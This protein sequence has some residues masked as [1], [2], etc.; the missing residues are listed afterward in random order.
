[1]VMIILKSLVLPVLAG[2]GTI[3]LCWLLPPLRKWK[4]LSASAF[5]LAISFSAFGAWLAEKGVPNFPPTEMAEWLGVMALLAG[6]AAILVPC[7]GAKKF[8]SPEIAAC[9]MG[10]IVAAGPMIAQM[11]GATRGHY[12]AD[13]TVPDH[14][15]M[16]MAMALGF[17]IFDR[18]A[19]RQPG[20]ILPLV[21]TIVFGALA[22]LADAAG[23]ITLTFY[24]AA[25]SGACF[26]ATLASKFGG[27]PSIGRGGVAAVVLLLVVC[28]VAAYRQGY[29]DFPWWSLLLV[30]GS[31][32]VLLALEVC[33][34]EKLPPWLLTTMRIVSVLVLVGIGLYTGLGAGG[35]AELDPMQMY[36]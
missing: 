26:I 21:F 4:W 5:G 8:P 20:F 2:G 9:L 14:L 25:I 13:M 16:G 15:A 31:P 1:M 23:W 3:A 7:T 32:L 33:W 10:G 24:C 35:E 6:I 12:F 17:L 18:I 27:S 30:A 11:M 34:L 28:P 22:P 36:Q 19:E 29:P